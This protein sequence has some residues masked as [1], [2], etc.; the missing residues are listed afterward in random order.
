MGSVVKGNFLTFPALTSASPPLPLPPSDG[1]GLLIY[2]LHTQKIPL[3]FGRCEDLRQ[4]N[5]QRLPIMNGG[6]C[7]LEPVYQATPVSLPSYIHTVNTWN[8]HGGH[9]WLSGF[10]IKT[11]NALV[12]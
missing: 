2:M 9:T 7:F 4:G 8:V 10:Q 5:Q 6:F 11:R 1:L 3:D 12:I